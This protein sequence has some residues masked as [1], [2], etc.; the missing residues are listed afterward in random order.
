MICLTAFTAGASEEKPDTVQSQLIIP[1]GDRY[2]TVDE[3]EI[4]T[5]VNADNPPEAPKLSDEAS[6]S[7]RD[8]LF[9]IEGRPPSIYSLPASWTLNRPWWHGMWINTAVL[10]GAFIGTSVRARMSSRRR[11]S[12][13]Q[14]RNLRHTV[15]QTLVPQ[16][17]Q[18]GPRM[19]PRQIHIQLG[20]S[21]LCRRRLFHVR[22]HQRLQFLAFDAL[23]GTH[24]NRS[25]GIRHRSVHGTTVVS[26]LICHPSDRQHHRRGIL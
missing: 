5:D 21:S 20:A 6:V 9:T 2:T 3:N 15:L 13:E 16:H 25:V 4:V 26:G 22:S 24:L 7:G 1:P 11:H 10:S 23:F 8:T 14:G 12:M 17:L 18:K 19:G